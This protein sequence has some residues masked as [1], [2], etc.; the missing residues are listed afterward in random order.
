MT[1]ERLSDW[2]KGAYIGIRLIGTSESG[3]TN[4]YEVR[5]WDTDGFRLGTIKWFGR[6]RKYA[7]Y[8]EAGCLFEETCLRDIAEFCEQET[9][10]QRRRQQKK[11]A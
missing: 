7:F 6:W 4:V 5:T 9:K 11:A 2:T 3:K 10:A 8:P 1:L